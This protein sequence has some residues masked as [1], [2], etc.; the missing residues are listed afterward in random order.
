MTRYNVFQ[1]RHLQ[2]VLILLERVRDQKLVDVV[3]KYPFE[4]LERG[5]EPG[6]KELQHMLLAFDRGVLL[7]T[8]H[9]LK[10]YK[11]SRDLYW[12]TWI[13]Q[14]GDRK[15]TFDRRKKCYSFVVPGWIR[16]RVIAVFLYDFNRNVPQGEPSKCSVR[17]SHSTVDSQ[18]SRKS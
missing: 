5:R 1:Y 16:R 14:H 8:I 3:D 9:S 13:R 10:Q 6:E 4:G 18:T 7:K 11:K 2:E 15:R 12:R 17:H